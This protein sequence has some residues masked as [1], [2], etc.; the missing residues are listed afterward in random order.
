MFIEN[1]QGT[2]KHPSI[3]ETLKTIKKKHDESLAEVHRMEKFF[4]GFKVRY[5]PRLDNRDT[6][7][8]VWIASSRALTPPDI[9]IEKSS[10]PSFKS[11]EPTSEAIGQDLMFN[12]EPE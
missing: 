7:H 11:A 2:Y 8:L 4:D 6:D 5:I 1:F 12:D 3:A 9:I 10:K